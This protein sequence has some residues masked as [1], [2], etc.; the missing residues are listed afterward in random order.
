[1]WAFPLAGGRPVFHGSGTVSVVP[2]AASMARTAACEN[3]CA[4]TVRGL[5]ELAPRQHLHQ[6]ALGHEAVLSQC[7]RT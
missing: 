2:P 6:A 4:R 1:M 5:V 7:L 3:P